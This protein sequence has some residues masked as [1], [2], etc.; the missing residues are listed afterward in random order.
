MR[1]FTDKDVINRDKHN[2]ISL[3]EKQ[4]FDMDTALV[5]VDD[6]EDCGEAV[7]S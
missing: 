4:E 2:G 1:R 6:R 5:A 7:A 3:A